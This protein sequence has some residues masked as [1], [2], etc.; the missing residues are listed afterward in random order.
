MAG[1]SELLLFVGSLEDCRRHLQSRMDSSIVIVGDLEGHGF[2]QLSGVVETT[3]VA[4]LQL[5]IVVE[6][7]LV[8]TLPW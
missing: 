8:A 5:E 6:R 2:D 4:E 7:F 3:N 1:V